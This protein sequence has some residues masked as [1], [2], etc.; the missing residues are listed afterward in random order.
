MAGL[1]LIEGG[2]GAGLGG[3]YT[4]ADGAVT[5]TRLMG[6]LGLRLHWIKD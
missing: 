2:L 3:G 5:D 1:T 4:F 6:V